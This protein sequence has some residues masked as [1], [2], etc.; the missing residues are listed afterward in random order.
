MKYCTNCGNAL[1]DEKFC[2]KCGTPVPDASPVPNQVSIEPPKS[3]NAAIIILAAAA[4]IVIAVIA[5]ICVSIFGGRSYKSVIKQYVKGIEKCDAE[6]I[7]DLLP[8]ELIDSAVDGGISY[9][10]EDDIIDELQDYLDTFT[11]NLEDSVGTKMKIS[12]KI[13]TVEDYDEDD[14]KTIK[15]AYGDEFDKEIKDAKSAKVKI[16]AS[17]KY[18]EESTDIY[19]NLIKLGGKWYLSS[20]TGIY[21]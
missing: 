4:V 15:M 11:E 8:Q 5:S 18:G 10:D 19:I 21:L 12:Y 1:G 3:S 7:V 2:T 16:I 9:D 14:I 13:K 6:R 17:G 20:G